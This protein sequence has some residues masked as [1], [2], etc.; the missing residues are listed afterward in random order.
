MS[1]FL[2][3]TIFRSVFY[4][5]FL[6]EFL[7]VEAR[8]LVKLLTSKINVTRLKAKLETMAVGHHCLF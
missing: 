3:L 6:F 4:D 8:A 5:V 2:V 1:Q 7:N